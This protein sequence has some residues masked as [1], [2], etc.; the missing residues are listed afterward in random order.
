MN[1]PPKLTY[2]F[3]FFVVLFISPVASSFLDMWVLNELFSR[4]DTL[5]DWLQKGKIHYG[6]A[7]YITIFVPLL[8]NFWAIK[9]LIK[10][11]ILF[12][13]EGKQF[14]QMVIL[15]ILLVSSLLVEFLL[16]EIFGI[17]QWWIYTNYLS[18]RK[19][20]N[21]EIAIYM[22]PAVLKSVFVYM[23]LLIFA[24]LSD[25]DPALKSVK[26]ILKK[27]NWTENDLKEVLLYRYEQFL[28][29]DDFH[30]VLGE[31]T[32]KRNK[33]VFYYSDVEKFDAYY[34]R[35]DAM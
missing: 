27:K 10:R 13:F 6:Y 18:Q 16:D 23:T 22:V 31:I 15:F 21:I 14:N 3:Y 2:L 8:I 29:L 17:N 30:K 25:W 5:M 9:Q 32:K 12:D 11:F 4:S 33:A 34:Q 7:E 1:F 28:N 24:K 20:W 19:I 35:K 26:H